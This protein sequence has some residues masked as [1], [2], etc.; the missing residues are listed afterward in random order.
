MAIVQISRDWGSNPSI[1]RMIATAPDTYETVS[2][3]GYLTA[4]AANIALA[5][6]GTFDWRQTDEVLVNI[7]STYNAETTG[8]DGGTNYLFQV[9]STFT[10]LQPNNG[11]SGTQTGLTAH[12]GGGQ[13]NG[14][15]LNP[16]FN[17]FSTVT[18][19]ADSATLP[20][21]VLGNTVVVTN[22]GASSMN[23]FPA[24]GDSINALSAN[25][26]LAVAA[27]A[28]TVFYGT[29]ATTWYSK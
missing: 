13:T 16:G 20:T 6:S 25:T 27:G 14:T 21:N 11:T 15:L 8:Y 17:Q 29:S 3:A 22:N 26:A 24:L 1:V 4:Q 9:N 18:T 2:A 5:N 10:S 28:T 7:G 19:A 12:A 23:V